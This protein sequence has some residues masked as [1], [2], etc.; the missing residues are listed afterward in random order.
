MDIVIISQYLRNIEDF[1]GNNSR[2]VYL[3]KMLSKVADNSVE[4]VTSDFCHGTKKNFI[5]VGKLDNIRV[6]ALHESGYPKNVCLKRFASHKELAENINKYLNER[7]MPDV[8]YMAVP[9]LAVADVVAKYCQKKNVRFIIDIQDLWPEAFRM[10]FHVPVLSTLVFKPMEKQADRIYALADE[11]VAVSKTYAD[12]AMRVNKK[13]KSPT[14]VYLGTEKA[15]FDAYANSNEDKENNVIVGDLDNHEICKIAYCGTLGHSY[16]LTC[17]FD[18]LRKIP[19]VQ[20]TKIQFIIMGNGPK[21]EEFEAKAEGLPVQFTGNLPY[22]EM[23]RILSKCDIVV[24][25]IMKGAAQS[26]INKHSDYVFS[27]LPIVSTQECTEWRDLVDE[28]EMGFNCTNGNMVEMAERLMQLMENK[29]LRKQMGRNSR[30]C[31]EEK[32]DRAKTYREI[33]EVIIGN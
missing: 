7:N 9:S 23:V 32:F 5:T 4:I 11:I 20:L 30:K 15:T 25:P 33:V 21:K 24:N 28:Y 13:C 29:D 27:G 17:V 19:E 16:D 14:V 12:R 22:P 31:A 8:I 26:I 6:T 2:F 3:A 1:E 10:V 18:A